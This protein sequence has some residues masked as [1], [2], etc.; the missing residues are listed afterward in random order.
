MISPLQNVIIIDILCTLQLWWYS[1]TDN[2]EPGSCFTTTFKAAFSAKNMYNNLVL[3]MYCMWLNQ[4]Q[5]ALSQCISSIRSFPCSTQWQQGNA[6]WYACTDV[7]QRH[8]PVRALLG[9]DG[10]LLS[11]I[12]L[13]LQPH[14]QNLSKAVARA[15]ETSHKI[16]FLMWDSCGPGK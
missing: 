8:G 6:I 11:A 5:L 1:Y 16:A 14:R 9:R 10:P 15:T 2:G 4:N 12:S 3:F 13:L 7:S